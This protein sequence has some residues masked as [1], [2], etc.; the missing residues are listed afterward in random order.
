MNHRGVLLEE[1]WGVQGEWHKDAICSFFTCAA[2]HGCKMAAVATS[3][4]STHNSILNGGA[5]ECDRNL[6]LV[7]LSFH[8]GGTISHKSLVGSPYISLVINDKGK[9]RFL[10]LAQSSDDSFLGLH[11]L[12]SQEKWDSVTR[13]KRESDY[14]IGNHQ[15]VLQGLGKTQR[16]WLWLW[17]LCAEWGRRQGRS[18]LAAQFGCSLFN[19]GKRRM[20][21]TTAEILARKEVNGFQF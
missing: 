7:A 15:C 19:C 8:Q 14:W 21:G 17:L 2:P 1:E 10:W 4:T 11:T 9:F 18:L 16:T 5:E 12:L 20:R 13:R 6:L 3:T